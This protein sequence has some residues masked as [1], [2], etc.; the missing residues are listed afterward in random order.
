M[1]THEG[2]RIHAMALDVIG[3][4]VRDG[5]DTLGDRQKDRIDRMLDFQLFPRAIRLAVVDGEFAFVFTVT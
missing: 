3:L 1:R 2:T 4:L 5:S